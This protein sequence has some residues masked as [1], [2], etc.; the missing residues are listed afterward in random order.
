MNIGADRRNK[1]EVRDIRHQNALS[2]WGHPVQRARLNDSGGFPTMTPEHPGSPPRLASQVSPWKQWR[3]HWPWKGST[4]F[5]RQETKVAWSFLQRL[6]CIVR[7]TILVQLGQLGSP[8]LDS[9]SCELLNYV[10][11]NSKKTMYLCLGT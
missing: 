1:W 8:N 6:Q 2:S 4:F 7:T 3:G 10:Q 5:Q 11:V 9:L